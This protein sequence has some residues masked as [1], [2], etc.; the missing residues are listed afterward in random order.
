MSQLTA[1]LILAIEAWLLVYMHQSENNLICELLKTILTHLKPLAEKEAENEKKEEDEKKEAK[2]QAEETKK[3]YLPKPLYEPY[4]TIRHKV[5]YRQNINGWLQH[6]C[7]YCQKYTIN[8]EMDG[9]YSDI[10][11]ELD[12]YSHECYIE[13]R[14]NCTCYHLNDS[15]TCSKP[16]NYN[17][18]GTTPFIMRHD[19]VR[20][21]KHKHFIEL[22]TPNNIPEVQSHW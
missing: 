17:V 22:K 15:C 9:S 7:P 16:D 10:T 1:L 11:F 4:D 8:I 14:V 13:N 19:I 6:T 5:V 20:E 2:A 21:G 18:T 3:K 12:T